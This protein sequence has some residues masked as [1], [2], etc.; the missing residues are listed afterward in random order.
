MYWGSSATSVLVGIVGG[1][2]LICAV[3][4]GRRLG[5]RRAVGTA[6]AGLL[7][8]GLSL[9]GLIE[10]VAR[11]LAVFSFNPLRWAGLGAAVVGFV[12]LSWSGMIPRLRRRRQTGAAEQP[13]ALEGGS[14]STSAA[15]GDGD[16]DEIEEILRR[17]G[18]S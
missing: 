4:L 14:G 9:S 10:V 8:L 12:M 5:R 1:L 13:P 16:L 7:L 18:I 2:L 6:G 15:G 3:L 11:A 17:R